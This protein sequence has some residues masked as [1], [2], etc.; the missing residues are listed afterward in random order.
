MKGLFIAL[1]MSVGWLEARSDRL[2]SLVIEDHQ[3]F[4]EK[5]TAKDRLSAYQK[6]HWL[7]P[8]PYRKVVRNYGHVRSGGTRSFIT[9]YYPNGQLKQY[10]QVIDNRAQGTYCEWYADGIPKILASV[11]GGA[12]EVDSAAVETYSFV[13][14]T[15]AF[16]REG[17]LLA[18]LPYTAGL[19]HGEAIYY[20]SNGSVREKIAYEKG[21]RHGAYHRYNR[22]GGVMEEGTYSDGHLQGLVL[23]YDHEGAVLFEEVYEEGLLVRGCYTLAETS[24]LNGEGT[25]WVKREDGGTELIE[26]RHGMPCGAHEIRDQRGILISCVHRQGDHKHG[27]ETVYYPPSRFGPATSIGIPKVQLQWNHD[28]LQGQARTWYPSGRLESQR[29]LVGN[30]LCGLS[31]AWYEDGALMLV[32]EYRDGLLIKG[33]YYPLGNTLP[34]TSVQ[35]GTGVATLFDG[36]GH[37]TGRI[38]YLDGQP[39]A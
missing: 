17:M 36:Q 18:Q 8:Q 37:V 33:E 6:V 27:L 16:D 11:S 31:M 7:Q 35:Q 34:V 30:R 23:G 20:H 10:L 3:G 14:I 39:V 32:E 2:V 29:E 26:Y 21:V 1:I 12:A 22:E 4:R 19:L 38:S 24:V 15:E 13:G 25:R 9:T 28:E 5:L